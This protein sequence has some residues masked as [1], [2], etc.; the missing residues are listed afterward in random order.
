MT[1]VLNDDDWKNK[2]QT[3]SEEVEINKLK[4]SYLDLILVARTQEVERK[5]KEKEASE[6]RAKE[7]QQKAHQ[8]QAK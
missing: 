2:I 8:E 1:D 4:K 7:A 6:K 5:K 3:L